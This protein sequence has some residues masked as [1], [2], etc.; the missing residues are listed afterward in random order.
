MI[1]QM[2]TPHMESSQTRGTYESPSVELSAIYDQAKK[3][4][5]EHELTLITKAIAKTHKEEL[6]EESARGLG[7]LLLKACN[8]VIE[9]SPEEI[10]REGR[11]VGMFSILSSANETYGFN[12]STVRGF[13]ETV[14]DRKVLG[15]SRMPRSYR[16]SGWVREVYSYLKERTPQDVLD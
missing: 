13:F 12:F 15:E 8:A 3:Y 2:M 5:S 4:V 11:E 1:K 16:M 14:L 7:N 6:K 9:L 10:A